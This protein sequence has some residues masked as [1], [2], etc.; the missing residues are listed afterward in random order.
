MNT[1]IVFRELSSGTAG[2]PE[3]MRYFTMRN[4]LFV[5]Q[6]P[7]PLDRAA[8]AGRSTSVIRSCCPQQ[9]RCMTKPPDRGSACLRAFLFPVGFPCCGVI[10]ALTAPAGIQHKELCKAHGKA[11]FEPQGTNKAHSSRFGVVVKQEIP[12]F[13]PY[14]Q[15][16]IVGFYLVRWKGLEPPAY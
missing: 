2:T 16:S 8:P 3:R 7:K 13:T 14:F 9:D 15:R 11:F 1:A 10:R 12:R 5:G 4:V 6:H